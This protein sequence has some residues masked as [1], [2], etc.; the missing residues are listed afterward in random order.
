[1]KMMDADGTY[2]Y[3]YEEDQR[4]FVVKMRAMEMRDLELRIQVHE[5]YP[6][7]EPTASVLVDV[8]LVHQGILAPQFHP[9]RRPH[10]RERLDRVRMAP[11]KENRGPFPRVHGRVASKHCENEQL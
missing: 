10:E 4:T 9:A 8:G 3:Y 2:E 11:L 5:E 7:Y 1:M 6:M